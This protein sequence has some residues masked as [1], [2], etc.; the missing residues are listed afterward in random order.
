MRQ[1]H[2]HAHGRV[3]ADLRGREVE[4]QLPKRGVQV[5]HDAGGALVYL[6]QWPQPAE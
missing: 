1:E 5:T 6:V 3:L 2:V 4:A